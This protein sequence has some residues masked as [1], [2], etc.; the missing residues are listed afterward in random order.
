[1][2][3]HSLSAENGATSILE[4]GSFS[5]TITVAITPTT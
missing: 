5:S 1:V 4:A 3:I 2:Q